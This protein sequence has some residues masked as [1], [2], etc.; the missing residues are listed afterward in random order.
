MLNF[1][2]EIVND[3]WIHLYQAYPGK[4]TLANCID[5]TQKQKSAESDQGLH[6]L[7]KIPER[8]WMIL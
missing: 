2:L 6:Y 1:I 5:Q 4:R 3:F 8:M 7:P